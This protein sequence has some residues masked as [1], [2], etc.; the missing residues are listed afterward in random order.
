LTGPVA[1]E[2]PPLRKP[3]SRD[4]VENA[5]ERVEVG[6]RIDQIASPLL[7]GR[8]GAGSRGV[9]PAV[10]RLAP[11]RHATVGEAEIDENRKVVVPEHD[12]RRRQIPVHQLA[13]VQEG[14]GLA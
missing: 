11:R 4:L 13:A 10:N 8:K 5:S 2:A 12:V 3:P 7:G 6:A 14:Q 9:S 1:G